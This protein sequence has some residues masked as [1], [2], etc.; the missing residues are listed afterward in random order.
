MARVRWLIGLAVCAVFPACGFHNGPSF[1]IGFRR[2]ALDLSYKD[3]SLAKPPARQDLVIPQP[4]M[5]T[6][7]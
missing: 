7:A 5:S 3:E 6:G 4:V 2:V 1:D